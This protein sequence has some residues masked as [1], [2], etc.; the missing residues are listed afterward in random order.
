[1]RNAN[2][3]AAYL[4]DSLDM[5]RQKLAI[6]FAEILPQRLKPFGRIDELNLAAPVLGLAVGQNPDVGRDA[7]VVEHVERQ[8]DDGLQPIV[9]DDP[10]ADVALAL[11]GVSGKQR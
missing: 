5:L 1:M 10:A 3:S 2:V 7:G 8:R 6:L 11:T 4:H 9:L